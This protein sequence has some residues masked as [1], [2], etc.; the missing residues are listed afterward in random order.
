M[1][2]LSQVNVVSLSVTDLSRAR[3]FYSITLG[4]G[5]PWFDDEQLG[6]IEWGQRGQNGN[7]AV[8]LAREDIRPG[9]GTTPVL[10]TTD[11][12]MLFSVLTKQGV[13]CDEPVIIPGLLMY[14]T[15]YDPDGNRLQAISDPS[16]GDNLK[17]EGMPLG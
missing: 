7:L 16:D 6:W 9:G 13:R 8:T 12:Q 1:K 3:D 14:C 5:S 2:L 11:C 15:F 10:N 4:L 17:K